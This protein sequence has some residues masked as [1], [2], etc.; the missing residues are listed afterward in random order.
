MNLFKRFGVACKAFMQA[1]KKPENFPKMLE[2]PIAKGNTK[3]DHS[4][5]MLLQSLQDS[6][7]FI[8]FLKEDIQTF[9]DAQVGAAA[10][11]IHQDCASLIEDVITVRPLKD[12]EEGA[13]IQVAK[14]YDPSE[15][16]VVGMVKGEPP[17]T[18]VL[19]HRGWKACKRSLPKKTTPQN[20]DI[21][22]PAEVEI[23]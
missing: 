11:K 20:P 7:R 15:I 1:F 19:V 18:G 2:Q 21:I 22:C 12:E 6:A 13:V 3:G 23:R 8:D 9:S 16:K 10:R 4:H 17:Y 5:L 14:G